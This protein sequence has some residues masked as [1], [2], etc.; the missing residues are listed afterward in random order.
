MLCVCV[1]AS[2][3]ESNPATLIPWK[4]ASGAHW[5]N[6]WVGR[7]D[8]LRAS[9]MKSKIPKHFCG[10][11][12]VHTEDSAFWNVIFMVCWIFTEEPTTFITYHGYRNNRFLRKLGYWLTNYTVSYPRPGAVSFFWPVELI[13]P[14][15]NNCGPY[16]DA[17]HMDVGVCGFKCW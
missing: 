9:S 1:S 2:P 17:S 7:S 3:S 16:S 5:I 12:A 6:G 10:R 11:A 15:R 14:F 8:G 13:G 4:R